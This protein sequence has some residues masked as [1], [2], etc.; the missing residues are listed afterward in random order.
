MK[1]MKR[2]RQLVDVVRFAR[3]GTIIEIGTHQGRRA[4][5]LC[6]EAL[7]YRDKVRYFGYD[8]FEDATEETDRIEMNGK[9]HG[10]QSD[11]AYRLSNIPGVTFELIKG[12][13]RDTL[14][15]TETFAD[16]VFIDGG[17]SL[18]TICGDYE[19]VSGSN[20]IV[21]DD[22]YTGIETDEFGCNKLIDS[23]PASMGV[24]ILPREDHAKGFG[25]K[26]AT[27]GYSSKW[28][29]TADRIRE[30]DNVR[31]CCM[32]RPDFRR[33]SD[34]IMVCDYLENLMDTEE[35]LEAIRFQSK[36]MFFTIKADALRDLAWWRAT[37]EQKFQVNEWF[38]KAS[39]LNGPTTEVCGTASKL[40]IVGELQAKGVMK[41]EIRYEQVKAN[42]LKTDKRLKFCPEPNDKTA[43][44]ACYGPSLQETWVDMMSHQKFHGGDIFSVSGTHDFLI[45]RDIIPEYHVEIDPRAH[46]A[47]NL[48]RPA[49]GVKYL[50]AS[51]CHPD[52]VD[53]LVPYDL[54]LFHSANGVDSFRVVDELEPNE[55]L[56]HGGGNSGLRA[57]S[58]AYIMG[59]R[60]F[61]IY[62]MD[63]SFRNGMQWAGRHV[64]KKKDEI[65]VVCDG[66]SFTTSSVMVSYARHFVETVNNAPGAT[67]AL[68]GDGLLQKMIRSTSKQEIAA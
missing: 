45:R 62:G 36:R 29:A 68:V 23:L 26:L 39:E 8:L 41:E 17:H 21:F 40:Y 60:D 18:E 65:E 12:N 11:V 51:C 24:E 25:L 28:A 47:E 55:F 58:V 31:S 7:K 32:W 50:I 67:F 27:I 13:T 22:Y 42:V 14:H 5:M 37:L 66:E 61:V 63:C 54:S 10:I 19:A 56:V 16:L 20:V 38:G 44:I 46:K 6:R 53:K 49:K 2:Y 43:L 9:G 3:P 57:I 64:G 52:L 48:M 15:G 33:K 4:E 30:E 35:T 34:L 59:Y 1:E